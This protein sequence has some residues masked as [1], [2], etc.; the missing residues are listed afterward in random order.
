MLVQR[1]CCAI[2][3]GTGYDPCRNRS[4][5]VAQQESLWLAKF[6]TALGGYFPT[7]LGSW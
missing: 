4:L 2:V 5:V 6:E 7:S 1:Y 3:I